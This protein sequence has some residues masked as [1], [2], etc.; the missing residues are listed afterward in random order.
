MPSSELNHLLYPTSK[1]HRTAEFI[2]FGKSLGRP[3][4]AGSED[5]VEANKAV[6]ETNVQVEPEQGHGVVQIVDFH[7]ENDL[8]RSLSQRHIQMIALAGAI[9]RFRI[10]LLL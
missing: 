4:W 2:M 6:T 5:D 10:Y 1:D 9:V 8:S 3:I 7:E